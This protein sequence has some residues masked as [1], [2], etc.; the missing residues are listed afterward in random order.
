M[1]SACISVYVA[2]QVVEPPGSSVV[3]PPQVEAEKPTSASVRSTPVS[4]TLPML[5]I[6]KL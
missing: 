4:V 1:I 5:V 6:E 2:W 3:M